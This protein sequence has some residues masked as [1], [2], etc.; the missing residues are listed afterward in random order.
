M[1]KY[2]QDQLKPHI[3]FWGRDIDIKNGIKISEDKRFITYPNNITVE[4]ELPL[5]EKIPEYN[6]WDGF[7]K[8]IE[9]ISTRL[10]ITKNQAYIQLLD[11]QKDLRWI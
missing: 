6:S 3:Q 10:G 9:T 5:E 2:Y 8:W 7:N 1:L 4:F 11:P